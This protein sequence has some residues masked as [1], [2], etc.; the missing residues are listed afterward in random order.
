MILFV[1]FAVSICFAI[2]AILIDISTPKARV[3][4]DSFG[5]YNDQKEA[6][7]AYDNANRAYSAGASWLDAGNR[8]GIPC[9]KIY[10]KAYPNGNGE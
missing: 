9:D 7:V 3:T 2:G 8:N 4:C 10:K 5:A 6:K 1:A